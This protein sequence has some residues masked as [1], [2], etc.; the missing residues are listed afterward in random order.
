MAS[1]Q[2]DIDQ[3]CIN[4]IRTLSIDAI[5]KANSGHPGTPMALAPVAYK[6]WQSFLR[7][8]PADPIWPNRDRFVL[9]AGHASMLLY[10][11]LHL[12]DVRAVDPD[13][14]TLGEPAVSLDDIKSFRQL[15]SRAP[16]HPEYRWTSG[17]E[18]TTGP[19]GQGVA[20]SVG[21]AIA[22]KWQAARYNRPGFGLFDF[23][24][25]AIAG[26]GCLMEGVSGEA[27]S[28]AGHLGLDNLCWIYDNNHITID[29][30]T[31]LA[32]D[33]DVPLRFEGYGW[34]IARIEDANDLDRIGAAFEE[35]KAEEGRPTLIVVDSHIGYGSPH[36]QDTAAAHGEPLGEEE[37]RETKRAY[38][39]P[40][41]AQFLV[42][43]GV[44]ERFAEGVG[45]RG[46]Q[47]RTAWERLFDSY[48]A[49]H[50]DLAAELEA[51]QKRELPEGWDAEIP[52]FEADEKGIATRKASNKV[53]NAIAANLP[54]LL[55]GSADLT[56]STSVRLEDDSDFEPG[57]FG[58]RQ[59]HYGIREHESAAISNGL[60]LSKLRPVWSTY[61]TFSDYARPAIRLSSL[62]EL[63]VIHVFTHDSIGLGEDGPTHQPVEQ[64]ASLRAIPGLDVIRP[65]DANEAAEAWRVAIDRR[66]QP[67]ALV[68]TRQDVPVID[69]SRYAPAE[70]LRRGGY[71]LA[72]A[73]S[74]EP[75]VILIA[76]GSEVALALA[77]HEE[78][79][80]EGISSRVVSLPCWELFDR[81][82]ASYRDEVLPPSVTARVSVEEA[83]TLGWDRY[84][85]LDG[86]RIGMHTFG[87]SAPLKDVLDKFGFTPDKVAEA[88]REV[89]A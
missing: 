52:A 12:A 89:L 44:R 53:Q 77:A 67:V 18:T 14:E 25:Y 40:E 3:L 82:D 19:L 70:G 24:V 84:V 63:P 51:M 75:D 27:A 46:Q 80:G 8:D 65:A 26:D 31:E 54:W 55:A 81:Q 57:A 69:R 9:S 36:K 7:Y 60:S 39:W 58:G 86:R 33:D 74:G 2:Q 4:T 41:D 59:L 21:M 68:L 22:S 43:D 20:T 71:V 6:L 28:I 50:P 88:A 48:R 30:H 87:S 38:D 76:T 64:L 32:Y 78:L 49:E 23:D 61:L 34:N 47:S 29:G 42:P 5:Q 37:V 79:S 62:M 66:H 83:S 17:V 85:G 11:L 1:T 73:E 35:F 15:D 16:G 10:S 72:D 56:D 13:Y 45:K